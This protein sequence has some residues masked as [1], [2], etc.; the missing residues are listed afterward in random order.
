[1]HQNFESIVLGGARAS[2]G[3]PSFAK[4][5]DQKQVQAVQAFILTQ[6]KQAAKK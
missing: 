2:L 6:A 4:V 1:V 3:M 5:F